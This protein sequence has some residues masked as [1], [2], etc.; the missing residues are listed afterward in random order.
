MCFDFVF[1]FCHFISLRNIIKKFKIK[2]A[3]FV[4]EK[5]RTAKKMTSNESNSSSS[6]SLFDKFFLMRK[7]KK[8]KS[9]S[10]ADKQQS[11]TS[12]DNVLIEKKSSNN[13][14]LSQ[15]EINNSNVNQ[16]LPSFLKNKPNGN[17][18]NSDQ[19]LADKSNLSPA[20][21]LGRSFMC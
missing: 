5:F 21:D 9:Q 16:L 12:N 14:N 11:K 10:S 19:A 1:L 13:S 3:A 4:K 2:I 7:N 18:N 15:N 6:T 17:C 8:N 20:F